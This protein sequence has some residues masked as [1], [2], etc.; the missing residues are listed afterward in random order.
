MN[1]YVLALWDSYSDFGGKKFPRQNVS[2]INDLVSQYFKVLGLI[3]GLR[4]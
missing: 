1:C 4:G 2:E 3:K